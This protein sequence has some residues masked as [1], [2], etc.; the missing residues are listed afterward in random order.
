MLFLQYHYV[1]SMKLA[2]YICVCCCLV[3]CGHRRHAELADDVA[4][5]DAV[6]AADTISNPFPLL[7][8]PDNWYFNGGSIE[9]P[10]GEDFIDYPY[11]G[12]HYRTFESVVREYGGPA[13]YREINYEKGKMQSAPGYGNTAYLDSILKNVS[14]ARVLLFHWENAT[15][16]VDSL[17]N[18]YDMNLY[19]LSDGDSMRVIYGIKFRP[20]MIATP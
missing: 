19:F 14:K 17:K 15:S 18:G 11:M 6:G 2:I 9:T 1:L 20:G 3:A 16:H 12:M 10:M 8:Y 7:S 13:F 4:K 5:V